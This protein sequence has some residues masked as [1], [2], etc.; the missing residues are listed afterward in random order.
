MIRYLLAVP[1]IPWCRGKFLMRQAM[2]AFLPSETL[3]RPK[4]ALAGFPMFEAWKRG[5]LPSGFS[6]DAVAGYVDIAALGDSPIDSLNSLGTNLRPFNLD[7]FLRSLTTKV[8][9]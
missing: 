2:K 4:T 1:A 5:G 8:H 3:L 9:N 6:L 7:F